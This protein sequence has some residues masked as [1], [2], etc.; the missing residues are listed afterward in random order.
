MDHV[1][2]I[3]SLSAIIQEPT[4]VMT[5]L[6]QLTGTCCITALQL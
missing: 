2:F 6:V 5:E 1:G 3:R 4:D